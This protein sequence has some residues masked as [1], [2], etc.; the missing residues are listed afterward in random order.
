MYP[1]FDELMMLYALQT[2]AR[3]MA[4]RG[5]KKH[6]PDRQPPSRPAWTRRAARRP[7][8]WVGEVLVAVGTRLK[9]ASDCPYHNVSR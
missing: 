4:G 6:G 2:L 1:R 7:L 3:E 5:D 9:A 8:A